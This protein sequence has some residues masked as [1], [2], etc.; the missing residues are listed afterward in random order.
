MP[1]NSWKSALKMASED[2]KKYSYKVRKTWNFPTSLAISKALTIHPTHFLRPL[3]N[4]QFFLSFN[5]YHGHK[6]P[7][8][9]KA[10]EN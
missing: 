3:S 8:G 7:H 6:A 5:F 1:S 9:L 10:W 2:P 4:S